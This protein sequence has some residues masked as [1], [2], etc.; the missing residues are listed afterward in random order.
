MADDDYGTTPED[1]LKRLSKNLI[2]RGPELRRCDDYYSG[3]HRLAFAGQKFR[4]AFGGLFDVFADNW[5]EVVVDAVEERLNI[6]GFRFGSNPEADKDAWEIWQENELDADSQLAHI[7]A[8]DVGYGYALVWA[9]SDG[10]P[11]IT[12]E[13]PF[14][15]IV[16]HK[17]GSRR[18]RAAGLKQWIADDGYAYAVVYLPDGLWKYRS[19]DKAPR[20]ELDG[21]AYRVEW[22]DWEPDNEARPLPN[23]FEAVSLV[24]LY[25]RPRTVRA[26]IGV[27]EIAKVIPIQDAVNK[28]CTDLIVASE[29]GAF[30]QRYAT[31]LELDTDAQG[32]KVLPFRNGPGNVWTTEAG[33]DGGEVRFGEFGE[34]NLGNI[35]KAIEMFVNHLASQS[36]TPP[37]YLNASADRLSGESIK[38]AE[39][40]LV[41]K[42]RRK[43]RFFGEAWE[44]VMR[45]SFA[46]TDDPRATET[47]AETVWADPESR[48]E[49]EHVDAVTK[50]QA[51]NVPDA[52]LWEDLGYTPQQI[53][54]FQAMRAMQTMMGIN[55]P[56][57]VNLSER[58]AAPAPGP[59]LPPVPAPAPNGGPR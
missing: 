25:N 20:F 59:A 54:R 9:D 6:E 31:G 47:N 38:A 14:E 3:K 48:T 12:V 37:H 17:A 13:S 33:E 35:V 26:G 4:E 43:T 53:Q 46:V 40:G 7:D 34:T 51:L 42:T 23:P 44:E 24:P 36:R 52:Q 27:S 1:W 29:F 56:G 21:D 15:T 50:K 32:N 10:K 8:L 58:F 16:A 11:T 41:A 18:E 57:P 5:C 49:S 39:T 19:R 45:L 55:D 2:K 22:V 30:R 28:L